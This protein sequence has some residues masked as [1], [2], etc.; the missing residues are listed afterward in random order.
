VGIYIHAQA[1]TV[2]EHR[3]NF[4]FALNLYNRSRQYFL[5][6]RK[7]RFK[8]PSEKSGVVTVTFGGLT[9]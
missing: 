2:P 8:F 7:S 4:T 1:S 3:K 6:L 5:E 9:F